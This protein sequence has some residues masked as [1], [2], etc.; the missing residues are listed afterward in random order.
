MNEGKLLLSLG[1]L[2]LLTI[3][4]WCATVV[5]VQAAVPATY[6]NDNYWTSEHDAPAEFVGTGQGSYYGYT[7]TG[8]Y[9]EQTLL[10]NSYDVR[11][12]RF[13]IDKAFF[14]VSD[15]GVIKANSDV[16]ALSIY[17]SRVG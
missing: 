9:F 8:K 10:T 1:I 2:T 15:R 12:F 6:T 13:S 17:L 4:L 11:L 16:A 14:Y 5:Y 7:K 3:G